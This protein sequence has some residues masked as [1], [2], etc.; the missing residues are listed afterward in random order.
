MTLQAY[1]TAHLTMGGSDI[2]ALTV[3][4]TLPKHHKK[5]LSLCIQVFETPLSVVY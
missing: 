3:L 1:V 2:I 5:F 4:P